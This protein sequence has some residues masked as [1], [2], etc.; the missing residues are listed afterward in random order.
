[1]KQFL[2]LVLFIILS[3]SCCNI[4]RASTGFFLEKTIWQA[5]WD[6]GSEVTGYTSLDAYGQWDWLEL[7]V[8][9]KLSFT[10]GALDSPS[11]R[12]G[13]SLP[14]ITDKLLFNISYQ[15]KDSQAVMVSGVKF[16]WKPLKGFKTQIGLK[17]TSNEQNDSETNEETF[18]VGYIK[19]SWEW[20]CR[21]D[22]YEKVYSEKSYNTY[23]KYQLKEELIKNLKNDLKLGL[24][25]DEIIR[26]YPNDNIGDRDYWRVEYTFYIK[27]R[28]FKSW[29]WDCEYRILDWDQGY[30]PYLDKR[31]FKLGCRWRKNLWSGS[32][33]YSLVDYD[34][35]SKTAFYSEDGAID[36]EDAKNRVEK[37]FTVHF[38]RYFDRFSIDTEFFYRHKNY[39]L[40]GVSDSTYSGVSFDLELELVK[41]RFLLQMSPWGTKSSEDSVYSLKWEYDLKDVKFNDYQRGV[42]TSSSDNG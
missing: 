26:D 27:D 14:Q 4:V 11:Y 1:M 40:A 30:D 3:F 29:G 6:E 22:R 31:S 2:S 25:Y 35:F 38:K 18:L 13:F 9:T 28:P 17:L 8:N 15:S 24:I 33:V 41:N 12:L 39:S 34:Y 37:N 36:D 19:D 32:I 10:D 16:N 7:D 5:E 21:L 23:L 42:S 20:K